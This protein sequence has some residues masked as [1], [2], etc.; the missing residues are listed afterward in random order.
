VSF[1]PGQTIDRVMTHLPVAEDSIGSS[2]G[3]VIV[4]K[5]TIKWKSRIMPKIRCFV[6]ELETFPE[7]L[8]KQKK[9]Q[10]YF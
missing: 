5:A 7:C 8:P 4:V 2:E 3:E 1:Q 10:M 9:L 6:Q